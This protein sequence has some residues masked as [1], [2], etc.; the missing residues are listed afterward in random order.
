MEQQVKKIKKRQRIS[1]W[2][3]GLLIIGILMFSLWYHLFFLRLPK[4]VI[5]EDPSVFLSPAN[6]KVIA[7][8]TEPTTPLEKKH[9]VVIEDVMRDTGSGSTMVSI[10]MTPMNVHY[11]RLPNSSKLLKQEYHT[12]KFLNAIK[13]PE[14]SYVNEYNAMLFENADGIKY[15]VIQIA[16]KMARRIVPFLHVGDEPKQGDVIGLI[17]LG[18]QVTIIFDRNVEVSAKVG[19]ILH[20]GVTVIGKKK[21]Q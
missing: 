21:E 3:V 19:D 14:A 2:I 1:L 5:Q 17:K 4:R 15:K 13:N 11:Q 18:S 7:V 6:G 10:M 8:I 12:G 9:R 20:E 16:G